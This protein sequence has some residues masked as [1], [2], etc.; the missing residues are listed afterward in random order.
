VQAALA[1]GDTLGAA[2]A[3][4]ATPEEWEVLR[5]LQVGD[6]LE[7]HQVVQLWGVLQHHKRVLTPHPRGITGAT[8][9]LRFKEGKEGERVFV[10]SGDHLAP[11]M[12]EAARR[13]FEK[14]AALG[15]VE[16]VNESDSAI[17]WFPK[18]K[19]DGSCRI[20]LNATA[21]NA[22]TEVDVD[23]RGAPRVDWE[24]M[25]RVGRVNTVVDAMSG[26]FQV[27]ADPAT[28][29][30][31]TVHLPPG[32][33]G[34]FARF[35]VMGMGFTGAPLVFQ[36][37]MTD[38][39]AEE[40]H[41][42]QARVYMDDVRISTALPGEEGGA[43]G[44]SEGG[45]GR[46]TDAEV[47]D[48]LRTLTAVLSKLEARGVYLGAQ[49]CQWMTGVVRY[50]GA[51]MTAEERMLDPRRVAGLRHMG[52][53]KNVEQL[54][55]LLGVV[56]SF[57]GYL[58]GVV[59]EVRVLQDVLRVTAGRGGVTAA[60][61]T[62][63]DAA[64]E[65]V[66]K[67]MTSPRVLAYP[68]WDRDFELECDA[69]KSGRGAVLYQYDDAGQRRVVAMLM[70]LWDQQMRALSNT[71]RE[72]LAVVMGVMDV[73]AITGTAH[74]TV[75]TD[76]ANSLSI[77][78]NYF[79]SSSPTRQRWASILSHYNVTIKHKPGA[80]LGAADNLSRYPTLEDWCPE[81]PGVVAAESLF[82][83]SKPQVLV[84]RAD[85]ERAGECK[86]RLTAFLS[87]GGDEEVPT[88]VRELQAAQRTELEGT[89]LVEMYTKGRSYRR[90]HATGYRC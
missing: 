50:L 41:G 80:E 86:D 64:Y 21:Y 30:I 10:R 33:P 3:I 22:I 83:T 82:A 77:F 7:P 24:L 18:R 36:E 14:M 29:R 32:M 62:A 61:T 90:G 37:L 74:V 44:S 66:M 1:S 52:R 48:H 68:R 31:C 69:S 67:E 58:H 16:Y 8:F 19:P 43:T 60:W 6:T 53:P 79:N 5:K 56:A 59:E 42:Q 78:S 4:G 57:D 2:S 81:R 46:L 40:I 63:A 72:V 73:A 25:R 51:V 12:Q 13:A 9:S 35:K 45:D 34:R 26:F 39:L 17:P 89:D 20:L 87:G 76:H 38:I 70:R 28:A 23:Q 47:Q 15:Y 49:K 11:G 55:R 75:F 88:F 54:R 71:D 85:G 27:P 84:V 65:R